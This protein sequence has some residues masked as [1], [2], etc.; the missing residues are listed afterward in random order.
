MLQGEDV[1]CVTST[2]WDAPWLDIHQYMSLLVPHNRV[3]FVERPITPISFITPGQRSGAFQQFKHSLSG[4]VREVHP[5]LF[6]GSPPL[7]LPL[8]Y[9]TG[10]LHVNQ[11]LRKRWIQRTAKRLGFRKPILWIFDPD[12]APIVGR[13]GEKISL[14]HVT[15]DHPTNPLSLNRTTSVRKWDRRLIQRVDLCI[16]TAPNLADFKQTDNPNTHFVSHGVRSS[17]FA[18]ALDPAGDI[19]PDMQPI[20]RPIIGQVGRINKRINGPIVKAIAERHPEWS[21]VFVG[22]V[23]L[24]QPLLV[25]LH[26]LDNVYFL[27]SKPVDE[28]PHYLRKMD[29]CII[30]YTL[31]HHTQ[32]MHPMKALEYLAA[33]K[34]VVSTPLPA[35]QIYDQLIRFADTPSGFT[36]AIAEA[37]VVDSPEH[38][39]MR[40]TFTADKTWANQL[41]KISDHIM[42]TLRQKQQTV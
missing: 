26:A 23:A 3:L 41:G 22:P 13:L 18:Q 12:A 1:I 4:K 5:Q 9:E 28:L 36:A 17:E 10:I 7:V 25:E 6:V 29:V 14:Y 21:L 24:E 27:G 2:W 11:W 19:P 38:Q 35:L 40:S 33:G 8:R 30:P 15:D 16:A 32:Y 39:R 37:L 34:P 31:D 42:H 20:P